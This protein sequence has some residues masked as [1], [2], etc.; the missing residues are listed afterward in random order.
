MRGLL[1]QPFD[2]GDELRH[3]GLDALVELRGFVGR[4]ADVGER[5]LVAQDQVLERLI[6]L[7]QPVDETREI[8][9]VP[10]FVVGLLREAAR[11]VGVVAVLAQLALG[12]REQRLRFL[13]GARRVP[14]HARL[15]G[16][17]EQRAR[18]AQVLRLDRRELGIAVERFGL[19]G[20]AA[21]A[22]NVARLEPAGRRIERFA[23]F[24]PELGRERTPRWRWSRRRAS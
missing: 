9:R 10:R 19:V 21:C 13:V 7:A 8:D 5:L 22:A 18:L 1:A 6:L 24:G 23:C 11:Q 17:D 4:G 14:R 16:L 12:L 20:A 2:V 3:D 15:L